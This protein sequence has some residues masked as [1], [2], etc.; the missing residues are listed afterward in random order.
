MGLH[1]DKTVADLH[2]K[3]LARDRR[4]SPNNL[5]DQQLKGLNAEAAQAKV[6]SNMPRRTR[7]TKSSAA[8]ASTSIPP[9]IPSVQKETVVI[10]DITNEGD[11]D[12]EG[13]LLVRKRKKPPPAANASAATA[14]GKETRPPPK[15]AKH[16]QPLPSTGH[17]IERRAEEKTAQASGQDATVV[18]SFPKPTPSR[19]SR[20]A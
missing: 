14:A 1:K 8:T 10:V 19:S 3:A 5:M 12:A 11:S 20:R 6:A 13:S 7:K 4:T 16:D 18:T 2:P 17:T 9:P 15:K